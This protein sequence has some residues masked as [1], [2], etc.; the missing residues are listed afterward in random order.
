MLKEFAI[1]CGGFIAGF[2]TAALL[3][4][5]QSPEEAA[6]DESHAATR[7]RDAAGF[8]DA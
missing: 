6:R 5:S 3:K 8:E 7:Y 4:I 2:I 1:V